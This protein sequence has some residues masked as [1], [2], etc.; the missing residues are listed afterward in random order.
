MHLKKINKII[1][2]GAFKVKTQ[3]QDEQVRVTSKDIDTLQEVITALR[4]DES[5]EIALQ[6]TNYR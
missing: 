2:D 3:I 5:I 1:K 6:F 4:T